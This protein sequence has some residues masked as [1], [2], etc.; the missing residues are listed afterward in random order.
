MHTLREIIHENVREGELY[1]K[2]DRNWVRCFACGHCCKIPDGQP[3]GLQGS[4]QPEWNPVCVWIPQIPSVT[5]AIE[6]SD[7]RKGTGSW[8]KKATG[9]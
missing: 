3:G 1:E 2:L 6:I 9:K 5:N 4:L 8:V 7:M